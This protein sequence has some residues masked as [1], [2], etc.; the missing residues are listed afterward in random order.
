MD[1]PKMAELELLKAVRENDHIKDTP[2][3]MATMVTAKHVILETMRLGVQAYI[4][5]VYECI[6]KPGKVARQYKEFRLR[7]LSIA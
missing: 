7:L 6:E 1:L 4:M 3:I 2:F 5:G